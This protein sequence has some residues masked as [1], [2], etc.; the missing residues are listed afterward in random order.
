MTQ[1]P[2]PQTVGPVR[3]PKAPP[4]FTKLEEGM[5][6]YHISEYLKNLGFL[7]KEEI[8]RDYPVKPFQRPRLQRNDNSSRINR[9]EEGLNETRESVNQLTE[10]FQKLN[11]RKPVA[12]SNFNRSY[13][14]P[15]KPINPQY[16]SSDSN[17][18]ENN[19]W[20]TGY[21]PEDT[22]INDLSISESF[23][24][25][26]SEF[27]GFNLATAEA[28]GWKVDKPSKFLV[29]GNSEYISEALGWYTYVAI[30]L[31]DEKDKPIVTII[32]NYA[33]IDNGKSKPMLWLEATGIR[34][35]KGISDLTNNR[36]HIENHGK[37]YTIPTFSKAPV[38]K[39]LPKE[40]QNQASTNSSSPNSEEDLKKSVK[41]L[42]SD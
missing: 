29:K 35:V 39:D 31:R 19:N 14:T 22:N 4:A 25:N 24:D 18:G 5:R 23:L 1:Q 21:E 13:F 32:G 27:D 33:C 2:A 26:A 8:D 42:K 37:T 34:K 3:Q 20:W 16:A 7:S 40:D 11:I 15:I 10:E 30:T 28:L 17:N 12:R 41:S 9:M 38:V 36:F 6:D